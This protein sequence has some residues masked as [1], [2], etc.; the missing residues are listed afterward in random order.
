MKIVSLVLLVLISFPMFAQPKAIQGKITYV[1]YD[2]VYISLGKVDG[3]K[4]SN[5]VYVIEGSDTIATLKIMAMSSKSSS[6]S[7]LKTK[8]KTILGDIVVST[9]YPEQSNNKIVSKESSDSAFKREEERKVNKTGFARSFI[10]INGRISSQYYSTLYDNNPG[11]NYNQPGVVLS[12]N[13][14]ENEIPVKLDLYGNFR[15]LSTGTKSPFGSAVINQS[16]IYKLSLEYDDTTNLIGIGRIIPAFLPAIGYIDGLLLSEYFNNFTA[17]AALGYQPG[18]NHMDFSTDYK[19][20]AFFI[21]YRSAG[22]F[23]YSLSTVYSKTFY[24]K[25]AE[26]EVVNFSLNLYNNSGFYLSVFSDIDLREKSG[27]DFRFSPVITGFYSNCN[28]RF[29]NTFSIGLGLNTS[30]P[31]YPFSTFKNLPDSLLDKN[32]HYSGNISFDYNIMSGISIYNN[33]TPRFDVNRSNNNYSN[34]TSISLNNMFSTG[35]FSRLNFNL[36]SNIFTKSKGIGISIRKNFLNLIDVNIRSQIYDYKVLQSGIEYSNT[37]LGI[38]IV[39]FIS[40]SVS[41]IMYLERLNGSSYK[42]TSV[43]NEISW[44]F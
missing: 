34:Y 27:S 40:K 15:S 37:T 39:C 28:Y 4:E 12:L 41:F 17:G 23:K 26:R 6:C 35:I 36:N 25:Y 33:F 38:D 10:D 8:R 32:L 16:R 31:F 24:Q 19:K 9:V 30:R 29:S 43:F 13:C 5:Q 11:L 7:I 20:Y 3:I 22:I 21:N 42:S 18:N 44:R 1:A 2:A 14:T